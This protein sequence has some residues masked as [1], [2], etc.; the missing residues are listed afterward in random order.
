MVI[1]LAAGDLLVAAMAW[2]IGYVLRGWL[3]QWGLTDFARPP[4]SRFFPAMVFSLILTA[5]IFSRLGLYAPKRTKSLPRESADLV[6][7]IVVVWCISYFFATLLVGVLQSRLMMG[8]VLVTWVV[9][10]ILFRLA[11]RVT[12]RRLRRHGWNLRH[13]AI[14]GTGRLGQ[15]LYHL[16]RE[17]TWTGIT[18]HYFV[19]D[20]NVR[21]ELWGLD[22][23]HGIDKID[24]VVAIKP[25][26]IV[27]VALPGDRHEDIAEVLDRLAE[28]NVDIRVAPD[29][30]AFN[31][32]RH[33]V[34]LLED[35]PIISMTASPQHGLNSVLK[36]SFDLVASL[37]GIVAL[38]PLLLL[39]GGLVKCT[40]RGPVFYRQA[41]TSLSG[42][43][44]KI[45]KFRT[46]FPD[47]EKHSGAVWAAR[48][49]PR[50]TGIGRILRRT[51]LD[52]LP[53][54]L[55]VLLGQMSLVGPRPERPELVERF[56]RT[57]PRYML[58]SQIKAGLTGWAQVHGFR[59]R[60]SMRKRIQ[61]DLYYAANW[62]FGLDMR[63]LV[64]TVLRGFIHPNAY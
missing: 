63:I 6:I 23:Y 8:S 42:E 62:T 16:L 61:Y 13:A 39:I 5:F 49:D 41:R 64:M 59:G 31:F 21:D 30:L 17:N 40:S 20:P 14:V 29:L 54:L 34:S 1:L 55:N 56:R 46:M 28:T 3:E 10:A 38:G 51:S 43:A 36:R 52:E 45:F 2:S 9:G 47:A 26:D 57:V 25:V 4:F 19:D 27:F 37:A 53:Q 48:D 35:L 50:V 12:L 58:R 32:L 22:V 60:T 18:P 33:E 24:V 11:A 44:F 15:H 7:A